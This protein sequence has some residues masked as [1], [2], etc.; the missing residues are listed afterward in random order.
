MANEDP[1]IAYDVAPDGA[2]L[3]FTAAVSLGAALLA[4]LAPALRLARATVPSLRDEAGARNA[5]SAITLWSRGLIA[6]QV[7]LSLLLLAGALLLVTTLRNFRTGDF[8]FDRQ[9]VLTMRVE[10]GRAG[11]TGDRRVAYCRELLERVRNTPGV[12]QAALSLGMPVI[13]SGVDSS[14]SLEGEPRDPDANAYVNEVT[15]GY[16]AT[17][18]T[19]LLLGRDFGPQDGPASTPVAI[20][21]EALVR[22]YFGNRNPIGQRVNV[23][24]RG[25]L[26]VVGV[27]ETT[28]YESL[29]EIESPMVYGHALQGGNLGFGLNLTVKTGDPAAIGPS[30]RRAVQDIAPVPVTPPT[31]LAAQIDRTLVRERLIAR[32]LSAFAALALLLASAGLYG[33][34]A[35]TV[36]RRTGE[37]GVRV[38][39]GATR[40]AVL[41]PVLGEAVRLVAIGVAIGVPAALMLTRLLENLLYG[42]T[43]T[44]VRVLGGVVVVLFLVA[45]AAAS[46]P[47]WRASRVNPLVALRYE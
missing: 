27:V 24:R 43:P 46:I 40:G 12:R 22:R 17:T 36:T 21:N 19:R 8:G 25:A 41:R 34:L 10:P 35:Y 47:A 33:V 23:G 2:V 37:I 11:Y 38:A 14:F 42:V 32:V 30:I 6:A 1:A 3:L 4:G 29:R 45:L 16:F 13:S 5:A 28:K 31:T 9:G 39:L 26:E 18:G 15:D 44:D 20:V 7:A